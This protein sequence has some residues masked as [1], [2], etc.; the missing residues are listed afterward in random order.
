MTPNEKID[1]L[2]QL[3]ADMGDTVTIKIGDPDQTVTGVHTYRLTY[4]V[5]GS[6]DGYAGFDQL[7]WDA[8]GDQWDTHLSRM[9]DFWSTVML[10]SRQFQ[11]NVFGKHMVLQGVQPQHFERWLA[12]FE[13]AVR[14]MFDGEVE[15]EFK[16]VAHRIA[17][18]LQY[19]FFGKVMVE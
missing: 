15:T 1:D 3:I 12:L 19:G 17:Q 16:T 14:R 9:V 10:G 2:K 4:L 7:Y 13:A 18:S 11:G 8:I 5:R 6:M